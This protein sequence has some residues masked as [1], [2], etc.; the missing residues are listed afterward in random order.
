MGDSRDR[1]SESA[2][3][4]I[5]VA[6]VVALIAGGSSPWWWEKLFPHHVPPPVHQDVISPKGIGACAD[7]SSPSNAFH[8]APAPNGS[9]DW[10]CD[11]QIERAWSPC[12]NLAPDQC[13]PNTNATGAK[14][15]FC[16]ELRAPGGCP[17]KVAECGQPGWLYPCFYNE[18]DGRCHAGGYELA[19]V[20]QC[21]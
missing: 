9:W 8:D 16:T 21:R 20:M 13:K 3:K 11:G 4:A 14:P 12:E 6:V 10:N 2:T 19:K 15:G 7:G 5:L 17:P 1:K 18:A